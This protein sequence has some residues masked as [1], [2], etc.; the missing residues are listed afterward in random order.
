MYAVLYFSKKE[1]KFTSL[2]R[3]AKT[4]K[5]H[6]AEKSEAAR[7]YF[8]AYLCKNFSLKCRFHVQCD[9]LYTV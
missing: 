7:I 4:Y 1:R 9:N 8:A 5:S 3:G 6:A 2:I